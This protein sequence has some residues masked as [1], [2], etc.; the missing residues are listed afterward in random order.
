MN[1]ELFSVEESLK[2]R[3]N[4]IKNFTDKSQALRLYPHPEGNRCKDYIWEHMTD[5]TLVSSTDAL[6][7][8]ANCDCIYM[9]QDLAKYP[10]DHRLD[11]PFPI[12][13]IAKVTGSELVTYLSDNFPPQL[14]CYIFDSS[15]RWYITITNESDYVIIDGEQI[16]DCIS[17][18]YKGVKNG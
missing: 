8:I 4:F 3:E 14:G 6:K 18:Y 7:M 16:Y 15:F 10:D 13:R 12:E 11:L 17:F 1:V 5:Y 9:M 2:L